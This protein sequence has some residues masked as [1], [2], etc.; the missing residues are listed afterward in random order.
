MRAD[1]LSGI[2]DLSV[3]YRYQKGDGDY[4]TT[5]P[6]NVSGSFPNLDT[7]INSVTVNADILLTK[8]TIIN[9]T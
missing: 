1:N 8:N 4:K 7:V 6:T 3:D 9:V 5:D 2:V